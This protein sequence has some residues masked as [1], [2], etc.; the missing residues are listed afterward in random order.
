MHLRA[1]QVC[2]GCCRRHLLAR[3]GIDAN[4]H[5]YALQLLVEVVA[6]TDGEHRTGGVLY[7]AGGGA[8]EEILLVARRTVG[9]DHNKW[10]KLF[11]GY[12]CYGS[13]YATIDDTALYRAVF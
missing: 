12:L 6:L 1:E 9:A 7:Y 13:G 10:G 11:L 5:H 4:G 2:H 3:V 8:A